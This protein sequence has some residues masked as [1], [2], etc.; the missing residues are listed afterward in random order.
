MTQGLERLEEDGGA[1]AAVLVPMPGIALQ[2]QDQNHTRK[3]ISNSH[4]N[5]DMAQGCALTLES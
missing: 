1:L 4:A 5:V 2:V 3:P